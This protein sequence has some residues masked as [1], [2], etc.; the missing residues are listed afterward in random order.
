MFFLEE[1]LSTPTESLAF[2]KSGN[3]STKKMFT[4][5]TLEQVCQ[6]FRATEEITE[7]AAYLRLLA[8][9]YILPYLTWQSVYCRFVPGFKNLSS[10][11]NGLLCSSIGKKGGNSG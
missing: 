10:P 3:Y 1:I 9:L 8:L 2:Q 6:T 7:P 11:F 4:G 5:R